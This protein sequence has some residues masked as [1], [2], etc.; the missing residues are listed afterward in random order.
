M[1]V[2]IDGYDSL[3][4]LKYARRDAELMRDYFLQEAR[5]ENVYLFTDN[6]PDILDTGQPFSSQP[7][8]GKLR[9]FLRTRFNRPFL[10]SGDNFWFFYSGHGLRH[11]DRDYLMPSDADPHPDGVEDTALPLHWVTE[12]LRRCGADNVVLVLD[13]CRDE[14]NAKGL[15]IGEEKQKGVITLN[16]CSPAE[17]SYEIDDIQQGAFTYAL[18]EALRIQGEGNC[19]TVERLDR[20]LRY[21][22]S[23]IAQR[24]RKPR[25]TPYAIVEPATK[26]HLIL[27]PK[28]ATLQDIATLRE[29]AQEAELEG[30]CELAEQLWTRVLAVSPADLRALKALRRIWSKASISSPQP[31]PTSNWA[32][33]IVRHFGRRL[34]VSSIR[35]QPTSSNRSR[36]VS[37]QPETQEVELKS[38]KGVDYTRLRDLLAAGKWKEADQETAKVML[39]AANREEARYLRVEDIDRFPCDDLRTID[40]LW[41]NYSNGKFGFSVQKKIYQSLG[42]TRDYNEKVWVAFG[43]RVGWR[44]KEGEDWLYYHELTFDLKAP[45]GHLPLGCGVRWLGF[46]GAFLVDGWGEGEE[47]VEGKRVLFSRVETCEV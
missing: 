38:E 17:R 41:V 25:Q 1:C 40:Q 42:G 37:P 31:Q 30:N 34:I 5:F 22:V 43:D 26:Y 8:Y 32:F 23:E 28:Q 39:Q 46:L 20:R 24:Y 14:Q 7:T 36:S 9:R 16:S 2:G 12:R 15:G 10:G 33:R 35:S 3:P 44:D 27:L 13:A 4:R 18:L 47:E 45:S 19:A 29:D 6:S 11:G 21:R